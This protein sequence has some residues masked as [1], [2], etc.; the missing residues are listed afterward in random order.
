MRI[1]HNSILKV[2][3]VPRAKADLVTLGNFDIRLSPRR[4]GQH[5]L[6]ARYD[7]LELAR[8]CDVVSVYVRVK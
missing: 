4:L 1:R 3:H 5:T 7:G 6:R 2:Q 8:A